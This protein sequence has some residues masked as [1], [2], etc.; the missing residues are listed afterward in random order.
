[1]SLP[2]V[3]VEIAHSVAAYF[4]FD[5]VAQFNELMMNIAERNPIVASYIVTWC[6]TCSLKGEAFF[7]AAGIAAG[8]YKLLESQDEVDELTKLLEG[9]I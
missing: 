1:M 9:K 3:Q 2:K 8:V 6:R 7:K 5:D 4:R